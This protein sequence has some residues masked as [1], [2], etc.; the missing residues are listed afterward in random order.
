MSIVEMVTQLSPIVA[1]V[2]AEGVEAGGVHHR[3]PREVT[4]ILL[5]ASGVLLD[6][7]IFVGDESELERRA[8]RLRSGRTEFLA[9]KSTETWGVNAPFLGPTLR[10]GTGDEIALR[11]RSD[12][13]EQT[14]LHW[15][16]LRPPARFD[17]GP[18]QPINHGATLEAR[19]KLNQHASTA[20]YHPHPHGK[21]AE[22]VFRGSPG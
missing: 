10:L 14:T 9:G 4:E 7:G 20:W 19:W 17:G 13:P 2:V 5:T 12:L 1:G 11:V 3:S 8:M 6:A 15:H 21:T 22:Q 16:G 18:H